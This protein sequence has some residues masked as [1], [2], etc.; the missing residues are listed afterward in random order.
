MTG[1]GKPG[2]A[3]AD[4][5]RDEFTRNQRERERSIERLRVRAEMRSEHEEEDTGV[6]HLRAEERLAL[7]EAAHS[8]APPS[9][10][11][12]T[13]W[14]I[15]WTVARK[16]PPMGAVLVALASIAAYVYLRARGLAP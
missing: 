12:V 3:K 8:S 11:K 1:G 14:V 6:V 16:F 4:R 13:A 7:R 9:A 15:V 10:H 2:D 5:A